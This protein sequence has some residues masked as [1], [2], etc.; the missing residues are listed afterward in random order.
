[1][2]IQFLSKKKKKKN[3]TKE[4]GRVHCPRGGGALGL[5]ATVISRPRT[6]CS[7][8]HQPGRFAHPRCWP[9]GGG[10]RW[11]WAGGCLRSGLAPTTPVTHSLLPEGHPNLTAACNSH[12]SC[13]PEHYSP[14]CDAGGTMFYSPC[15][16]GCR[17]AAE[18]DPGGRQVSVAPAPALPGPGQAPPSSRDQ[19]CC[20]APQVYRGCSC[21]PPSLGHATAGKCTSTCQR[22]PLLLVLVFVVIIFTFL[23]SIPAL[24]ATLR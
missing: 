14:V 18:T 19:H 12:C 2:R 1:M 5:E 16:A 10:L 3:Q 4:L 22:K 24:T 15:H 11:S 20:W 6:V 17:V 13:K 23:S 9:G 7:G 21:V 8:W